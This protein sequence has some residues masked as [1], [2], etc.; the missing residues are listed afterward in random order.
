VAALARLLAADAEQAKKRRGRATP[1]AVPAELRRF[2]G[3][4]V[5]AMGGPPLHV[6]Y[7]E[8]GLRVVMPAVGSAPPPPPMRLEPT[9]EPHVFMVKNLRYAGEPLTFRT[10][11]E[12]NVTGLA[13]SGFPYKK[14]VPAG[15]RD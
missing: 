15:S 5:G 9:A 8:G 13:A 3:Y 6:E 11:A 12:G 10:D 7:R 4:Y 14:L 2:L 1:A